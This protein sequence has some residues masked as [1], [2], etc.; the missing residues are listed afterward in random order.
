MTVGTLAHVVS[1]TDPDAIPLAQRVLREGGLVVFPT[2]T[3]YGVGAAV[4]CPQAVARLYTVKGRPLDRPIPVLVSSIDQVERLA[5]G[6]DERV[7]RLLATFWPGA[8]TVV[9]PAQE[10]LPEEIVRQTGTVGLRMPD[11]PVALAII[12]AAGGALATTSANRSG[13]REACTAEEARDALGD[14]VELILDG[15][16]SPG[17][18]P[19][20]VVAVKDG[21]LRV[22][23]AGPVDP[24][25]IRRVLTG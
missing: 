6:V 2:D 17:G 15:G 8:L 16:R 7:K 25:L 3:V 12:E 1:V 11:H 23:R 20:T 5:A 4:D 22:L 18:R 24:E 13:E 19:S 21:E 10:W 14:R 9:V